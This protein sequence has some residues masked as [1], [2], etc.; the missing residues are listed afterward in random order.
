MPPR[1]RTNGSRKPWTFSA[2]CMGVGDNGWR[3]LK[4]AAVLTSVTVVLFAA[5]IA[6][7][8][9][10][11]L[12]VTRIDDVGEAIA[13]LIAAGVCGWAARRTVGRLRL[14][15]ILIA[16]SAAAWGTGEV[17]WAV[18]EVGLGVAVPFP[19]LADVGF[20][21]AVPFAL[22]GILAF[23]TRPR[24]TASRWRL[25]LDGL[26]IFL[27]LTFTAWVFGLREVYFSSADAFLP[28][29]VSL[30]YPVGDI[31][32]GTVL[33]LAIRRATDQQKGRMLLL[34]GG[35][36]ANA[37]ADSAFAYLTA[38]NSFGVQGSVLDTGWVAGYLMIALAALWP[39]A[40]TDVVVE[41]SPIDMWQIALPWLAVLAAAEAGVVDALQSHSPDVFM[42][43]LAGSLG[44]LLLVDQI[45]AHRDSFFTVLRS[46]RSEATL[47]EVIAHEPGGVVRIG[48]DLAIREA[49]PRFNAL[50][51]ASGEEQPGLPITHYFPGEEGE[52]VAESLIS[53]GSGSQETV[54]SDSEAQR[55]DGSR[56]W[57]HW[58]ATRV[59][60]ED[61][62]NDYFIAM[63][64]DITARHE[65]EA[66]AAA[67][68]AVFERLN[69]IKT[70]F[71]E[72]VS[73][74]FK[75][76][77]TGIQTF[78]EFMRITDQLNVNDVRAFASDIY[79]DAERLDRMV[80]EVLDLD[81][82]E[83]KR[84]S[85]QI[86]PVDLNGVIANEVDEATLRA[87]GLAISVDLDPAL[88]LVAGD[89]QKLSGLMRTLMDHAVRYSPDGG[90][91][92]VS[93]QKTG[94]GVEVVVKDQGVGVRADFD[95]RLFPQDDL[96][97]N[98]PI[99]RVVGTGLGLGIARHVV[100]LHGGRIW[101]ER[102]ADQGSEFHFVIPLA[103]TRPESAISA[104]RVP[105]A[106][107][108]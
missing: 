104:A 34:L 26:V 80:T 45:L 39:S 29:M 108:A 32:I 44:G 9:W 58:S 10:G 78:S 70:E 101:V 27:S 53:L 95:N 105:H 103:S 102:L 84:A 88:P 19:S 89:R 56:V 46:W 33:I 87:H 41:K 50:V 3:T 65:A 73:Q 25:A 85:L 71:L 13:A 21:A 55:A 75:T 5:S 72:N 38:T 51:R 86:E 91:I 17:I 52:R 74:E 47:A 18:Y 93:S 64:E 23:S 107:V 61:G 100:E 94:G 106:K 69:E 20:L 54:E 14:A 31:L 98:N 57:L 99:R 77:L 97:S 7:Q 15:W 90:T 40:Q 59:T 36:A 76:A 22:A 8:P 66:A 35:L 30:A 48:T 60:K 68:L 49:N 42:D 2:K 16:I 62:S 83:T 92:T 96:Y 4:I 43:V 37:L 12:W 1:E 6:L 24:G 79:R 63:F 11:S 82:V 28:R 81:R 67:S